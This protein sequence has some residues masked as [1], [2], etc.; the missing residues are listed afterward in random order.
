MESGSPSLEDRKRLVWISLFVFVLFSLL[1]I[2]FYKIQIIEGE[3]WTKEAKGQHQLVVVEPFKRGLFYSNN[4]VKPG[5]PGN[6]QPF[7]ID[8]PKF[9]LYIDPKSIPEGSR[10]EAAEKITAILR[11][12]EADGLKIRAQFDKESRSRKLV[13]WLNREQRDRILDWWTPFYRQKKI[14]RNAIFFIQDY[15]RSYPFGKLLGQILHTVRE[16][17]DAKTGQ[18]IPT[19]G[20]EMYF[21]EYLSGKPGKRVILRSPRHPLDSGKVISLPEHGADIYLT[22]NHYLQAIAEEEICKAVKKANAKG[23]WAILMDPRTGEI[24]AWAQYPWFDPSAYRKFYNDPK[25]LD[26]TK[27]KAV[28]DPYEPGSTFK[29]LTLAICLKANAELK[30]QGKKPIF[31]ARE[32]VAVGNGSFPGR[33]K[34]IRD[35]HYHSYLNLELAM[36]K[37]S[38]IYMARMIQRVIET[39]G[40][41]WYR[42]ILQD[43]F[44][45]GLKTGVE[46]PAE[47][48]GLLPMLGKKHPNGTLEWS[49]PTPF[50]SRSA[51]IF[52]STASRCSGAM[53][54]SRTAVS[55]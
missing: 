23:G 29:P 54:S 38:N 18:Y 12:N 53:P 22:I 8:V 44:G 7:V 14:V 21:D 39:L 13:M 47:T 37:S 36:Q 19:G 26:D 41:A 40:P 9:H 30:K 10:G 45:F 46:L 55:M 16:E 27:V 35:T 48:V 3:K 32:K 49:T 51:T 4:E 50:P 43:V 20:L 17:R 33:S 2:Q 1:I 5:H 24:L 6:P 11:L 28:T 31:D 15:K 42:G 52:W 25:L 34:P